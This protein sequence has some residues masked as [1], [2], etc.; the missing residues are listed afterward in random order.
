MGDVVQFPV[1]R[2]QQPSE[3]SEGI[4]QPRR[5][6]PSGGAG[7]APR[8]TA[9]RES[10]LAPPVAPPVEAPARRATE[11][12]VEPLWRESVGHE[13]REERLASGKRLVDVAEDAGVSPQY[14]S[15]VER[16]L[17]DPSSELLAAIAGALGLSVAE[18]ATR[19]ASARPGPTM[20][21]QP[22][23]LAA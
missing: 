22:V 10:P 8:E 7:H 19:V 2:E 16:G 14:L 1:R 5:E 17:K 13:L 15:E 18:I 23:C 9:P 6:P 4:A 11:P 3:E 21:P 20:G 12:T